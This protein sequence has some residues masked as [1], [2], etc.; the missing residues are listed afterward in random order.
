MAMTEEISRNRFTKIYLTL[1]GVCILLAIV[2]I[3]FYK[4]GFRLNNDLAPVRVGSVEIS[5]NVDDPQIIL[6][7]RER[8][9]PI[10][11]GR[12]NLKNITPGL[13]SF[14]VSKDGFWPW[15]KTVLVSEN[16]V[17]SLFAFMFPIDG[18]EIEK[19]SRGDK[20]N[21]TLNSLNG[22]ALPV[23]ES[24]SVLINPD[25]STTDWLKQNVPN[26]KISNDGSTA[27]YID[28]NTIYLAWISESEPPPHYFCEENPC[29]PILPVIVTNSPIKSVDFFKD[30]RD[31]IIFT[32]GGVIYAIEADHEGTQN[33]QPLYKGDDPYFLVDNSGTL[34][35]KDGGSLY[36][37]N[38]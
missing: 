24:D 11:N 16:N 8:Q 7:N 21:Q 23:L 10:E 28:S 32:S 37:S 12:Y 15:A 34:F 3:I 27:L 33:F 22:T 35:I 2:A 14:V 36:S 13:H 5:S 1:W 31:L 6:N 25:E 19:I 18:I 26:R 30:R 17:R 4:F 9:I 38:L 29:K 20:Y